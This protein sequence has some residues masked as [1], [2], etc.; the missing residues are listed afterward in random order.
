MHGICI[1]TF[2]PCATLELY[3]HPYDRDAAGVAS[4]CN[5]VVPDYTVTSLSLFTVRTC[6]N[7]GGSKS[8]IGDM[9]EATFDDY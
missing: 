6:E 8:E 9:H 4:Q 2:E 1:S 7:Y 5:S 3:K